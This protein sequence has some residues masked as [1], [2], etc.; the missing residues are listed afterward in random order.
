MS[1]NYVKAIFDA[2]LNDVKSLTKASLNEVVCYFIPEVTKSNGQGMYPGRT[3]YQLV[4]GIQKHL[5]FCKVH[6]K[7][8]DDIEFDDMR[9][10]L[11]NIMKERAS[12]QIGTIRK[13]ADVITYEQKEKMWNEGILGEDFPDTLHNTVLYLL[14]VNLALRAGDEHYCLRRDV[15][16]QDS[17]LSFRRNSKGVHC[18]VYEEDTV[19]KCNDGGLK[20]MRKQHKIVWVHPSENITKCPVRLVDKYIGLCPRYYKKANFYLQSL[21]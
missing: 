12:L 17:Q 13:Q 6:W 11:D 2:N 14:G 20:Q 7:L 19:T 16:G 9:I 10:V 5:N 21:Q 3:L 1:E 18:L 8:I 15:P 4:I